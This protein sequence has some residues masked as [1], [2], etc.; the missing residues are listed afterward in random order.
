E[1]PLWDHGKRL[2]CAPI[3]GKQSAEPVRDDLLGKGIGDVDEVV[4]RPPG[5][6]AVE[7]VCDARRAGNAATEDRLAW[8]LEAHRIKGRGRRRSLHPVPS[9][10][11]RSPP[12]ARGPARRVSPR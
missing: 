2:E 11:A 12:N 10:R 5:D 6:P 1:E 3:N 9:R 4:G 7:A 8:K